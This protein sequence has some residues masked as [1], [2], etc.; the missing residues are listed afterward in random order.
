MTGDYSV[1]YFPSVFIGVSPTSY[2]HNGSTFYRNYISSTVVQGDTDYGPV[3]SASSGDYPNNGSSGGNWYVY[4]GSDVIDPSSVTIPASIQGGTS[5]DITVTPSTGKKYGGTVSYTYQYRLNGGGWQALSWPT[6][7]TT[8]RLTVPKGTTS[9]QVQVRAQ[10]NLGFTSS[11]W[12]ASASVEVTNNQPPTAPGSINA[13]NVV[14]GQNATIT[15]TGATDPDGTV[16]SYVYERSVDDSSHWDI[17]ATTSALSTTDHISSD[18][19]TVAYRAKAVDNDGASGPYVT[20]E[21]YAVNVGWITIGGSSS[22]MGQQIKPFTLSAPI[23]VSGQTGVTGITVTGYLDGKKVLDTILDQGEN[24]EI[25]V[26]TRVLASGQHTIQIQAEKG[27]L[28]PANKAWQFSIPFDTLPDG[29]RA[30]QLWD[31]NQVPIFPRTTSQLVI[32]KNGLPVQNDLDNIEKRFK[33]LTGHLEPIDA[34]F[35]GTAGAQTELPRERGTHYCFGVYSSA[36]S[37]NFTMHLVPAGIAMSITLDG[38]V[39]VTSSAL[40]FTVMLNGSNAVIVQYFKFVVDAEA[41]VATN[42]SALFTPLSQ[43]HVIDLIAL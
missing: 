20:S 7:A 25:S 30:E 24:A 29:G 16:E 22:A 18:W 39:G 17:I 43:P 9:V 3:A 8:Q 23:S 26:D 28:L 6:T 21:Q 1:G 10:D 42:P 32:G 5:I 36:G 38:D 2:S 14:G 37:T 15:I 31:E 4:R 11:T 13:T 41:E 33:G 12:V 35:L 19:G 34:V 40:K 27:E